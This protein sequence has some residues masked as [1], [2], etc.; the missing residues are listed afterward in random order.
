MLHSPSGA[1]QGGLEITQPW[2]S[3]WPAAVLP[4]VPIQAIAPFPVG[5]GDPKSECP[6]AP[7]LVLGERSQPRSCCPS[8]QGQGRQNALEKLM[9]LVLRRC[10]APTARPHPEA[11]RQPPRWPCSD[12]EAASRHRLG[13]QLKHKT[14]HWKKS[15]KKKELPSSVH[16]WFLWD[17]GQGKGTSLGL[18]LPHLSSTG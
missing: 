4:A 18:C 8:G 1:L 9:S 16:Q 14:R 3:A 7:H 12:K 2:L 10:T 15:K 13:K 17:L 6:V 5:L 11:G